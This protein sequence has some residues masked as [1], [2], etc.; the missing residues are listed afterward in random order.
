M[1]A[2]SMSISYNRNAHH[3]QQRPFHFRDIHSGNTFLARS[4]L[5]YSKTWQRGD[6]VC[7]AFYCTHAVMNH[8]LYRSNLSTRTVSVFGYMVTMQH[9]F[10]VLH[11]AS[12]GSRVFVVLIESYTWRTSLKRVTNIRA[13]LLS[14]PNNCKTARSVSS[15]QECGRD[16]ERRACR[17][18]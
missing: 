12:H 9:S 8:R 10:P 4:L 16:E 15:G 5:L 17:K 14:L 1:I 11:M 6:S 18:T 2:L 13:C 3:L 7:F